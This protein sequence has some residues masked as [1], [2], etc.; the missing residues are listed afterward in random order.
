[1]ILFALPSLLL[2]VHKVNIDT[3]TNTV[4][5]KKNNDQKTFTCGSANWK[6]QVKN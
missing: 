1:M 2:N 3:K 6:S 5:G 4:S